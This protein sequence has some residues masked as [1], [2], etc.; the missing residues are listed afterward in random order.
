MLAQQR[1]VSP[2][3]YL[4][5]GGFGKSWPIIY[6]CEPRMLLRYRVGDFDR[7]GQRL[8]GAM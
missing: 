3:G 8:D 5:G 4:Q 1:M 2:H 6:A 7:A